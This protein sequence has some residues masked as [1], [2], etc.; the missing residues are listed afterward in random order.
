MGNGH[1]AGPGPIDDQG[2]LSGSG[3]VSQS[4]PY[5][6]LVQGGIAY[7]VAPNSSVLQ[8]GP[9]TN[10]RDSLS[11]LSRRESP[12]P[13]SRAASRDAMPSRD[14]SP[15]TTKTSSS[16]GKRDSPLAYRNESPLRLLNRS[17]RGSSPA[18]VAGEKPKQTVA[19]AHPSTIGNLGFCLGGIRA[20]ASGGPAPQNVAPGSAAPPRGMGAFRSGGPVRAKADLLGAEGNSSLRRSRPATAPTTRASGS[21]PASPLGAN[22]RAGSSSRPSSPQ[23]RPPSPGTVQQKA[24]PTPVPS[25]P[26]TQ[27]DK[28]KHRSLSS[29][30][31]QRAPSPT[32]AFNRNPSP[33]RPRWRM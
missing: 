12:E 17:G 21:R 31:R 24:V 16:G 6:E 30:M 13:S 22:N 11:G 27:L 14:P 32:P 2:R 3:S 23:T 9:A 33:S 7:Q 8:R 10:I 1:T 18:A 4:A 29:H 25:Y 5:Q 20:S 15:N 19:M 26:L 28:T